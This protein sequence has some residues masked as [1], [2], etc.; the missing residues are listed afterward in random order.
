MPKFDEKSCGAVIFKEEDG[1]I[2][3]LTVEYKKEKA[4]G[5]W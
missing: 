4:T 3:Y 1:Q 5:D 2:L